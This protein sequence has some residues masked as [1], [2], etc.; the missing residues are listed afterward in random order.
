MV[1]QIFKE[2]Y[3]T[4]EKSRKKSKNVNEVQMK[5]QKGSQIRKAKKNNKKY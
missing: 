2:W 4:P 3:T 5:Y 1:I